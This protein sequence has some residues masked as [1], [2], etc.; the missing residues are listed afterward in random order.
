MATILS[1]KLFAHFEQYFRPHLASVDLDETIFVDPAA[2]IPVEK[3]MALL[4]RVA[5]FDHPSIGLSLGSELEAS[6]LG[7]LGYTMMA[8]A[9]IGELLKTLSTYIYVFA[10]DNTFRLDV[11]DQYAVISYRCLVPNVSN[12]QHDVEFATS[13]IPR[14]ITLACSTSVAPRYVEFEHPKPAHSSKY[15]TAFGCAARF[16]C[17]GN[18]VHYNRSVLDLPIHSANSRLYEALEFYLKHQLQFRGQDDDLV[19]KLK[20]LLSASLNAGIPELSEIAVKL[21]MGERTLQ[22]RLSDQGVVF[23]DL[24]DQ[25]RKN[26]ALEYVRG[27]TYRLTDIAQML[28]Y[29]DASSFTR[30]F[31]RWTGQA[32]NR[33]RKQPASALPD[34]QVG[35]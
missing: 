28:G 15:Y 3:Y 33:L 6:D 27:T 24:V 22:R 2:E 30:A 5:E 8:A 14:L 35:V 20:H 25:T 7:V 10:Q 34:Y 11:S 21:G 12:V 29:T 32:P 9:N 19:R 18:R 23:S 4:E 1:E 13:A 17:T 31:R 26:I 16:E